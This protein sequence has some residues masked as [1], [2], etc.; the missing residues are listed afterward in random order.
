[1]DVRVLSYEYLSG[2][3]PGSPVTASAIAVANKFIRLANEQGVPI[4]HLKLQ[5]L[6]YF[7]Q[8]FSLVVGDKPAFHEDLQAWKL[9]PV[10]Q[11]VYDA[12]RRFGSRDLTEPLSD[13]FGFGRDDVSQI[14]GDLKRLIKAT[15]KKF[16]AKSGYSLAMDTHRPGTPWDQ[17]LKKH[18][19]DIPSFEI[20]PLTLVKSWFRDHYTAT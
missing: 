8:G 7:V 12:A 18:D 15:W 9:G 2:T 5:K 6:L 19:G 17:V 20:I 11:D 3:T 13:P 1:M 10:V 16:G 4:D 14:D